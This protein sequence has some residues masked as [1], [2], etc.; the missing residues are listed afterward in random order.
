MINVS[1]EKAKAAKMKQVAVDIVDATTKLG[2]SMKNISESFRG[3]KVDST[4]NEMVEHSTRINNGA[5]SIPDQVSSLN[6][7]I[8]AVYEEELEEQ[9]RLEASRKKDKDG[10]NNNQGLSN[11]KNIK[12]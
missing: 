7:I 3:D 8:D 9:K 6:G 4:I 5:S 12:I 11:G 10:L 2:D 1:E